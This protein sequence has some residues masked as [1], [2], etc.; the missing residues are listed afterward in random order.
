VHAQEQDLPAA[1]SARPG[2]ATAAQGEDE[3]GLPAVPQR[4]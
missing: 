3:F 1:P 4:T 2:H